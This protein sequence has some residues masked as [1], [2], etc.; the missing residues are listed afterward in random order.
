MAV[1]GGESAALIDAISDM[2]PFANILAAVSFLEV[3]PP[4]WSPWAVHVIHQQLTAAAAASPLQEVKAESS[5]GPTS[6][7]TGCGDYRAVR[8]SKA[9]ASPK[10]PCRTGHQPGSSSRR[11]RRRSES[12]G[13]FDV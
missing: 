3:V 6:P 13:G 10:C 9:M 12:V 2:R 4:V 1:S 5:C 8:C 11:V 7:R